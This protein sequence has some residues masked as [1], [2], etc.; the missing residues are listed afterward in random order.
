MKKQLKVPFVENPQRS[1][2]IEKLVDSEIRKFENEITRL[3][4]EYGAG[5][6]KFTISDQQLETRL[7]NF[8][9][10]E[11][12]DDEKEPQDKVAG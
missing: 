8:G 10:I 7:A 9:K 2:Q 4:K 12:T 1:A 5:K 6:L 11:V 3:K